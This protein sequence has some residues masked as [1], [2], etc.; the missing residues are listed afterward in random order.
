MSGRG[1]GNEQASGIL[2]STP[3]M[4][5]IK[6]P[7]SL[8]RQKETSKVHPERRKLECHITSCEVD[9]ISYKEH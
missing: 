6:R 5:K 9:H 7:R 1:R 8:V 3:F 2:P 4:L